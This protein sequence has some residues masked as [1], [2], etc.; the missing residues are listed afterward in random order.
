MN[1]ACGMPP[2]IFMLPAVATFGPVV[3]AVGGA[4][5]GAVGGVSA[6]PVVVVVVAAVAGVDVLT[7]SA[8]VVAVLLFVADVSLLLLFAVADVVV[9][10]RRIIGGIVCGKFTFRTYLT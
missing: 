9:P 3:G 1:M 4:V 6:L 5:D 2:E 10:L 7:G 8:L